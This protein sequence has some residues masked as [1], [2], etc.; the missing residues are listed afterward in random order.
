[1]RWKAR[2][3]AQDFCEGHLIGPDK[4][5]A[6]PESCEPCR[7]LLA[8]EPAG[9]CVPDYHED[10]PGLGEYPPDVVDEARKITE[11]RDRSLILARWRVAEP[12]L[13][14]G[15]EQERRPGEKL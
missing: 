15:S 13:I 9:A 5:H 1:M 14:H 12:S 2:A 10:L 11:S 3:A 4:R 8:P 6:T 7:K